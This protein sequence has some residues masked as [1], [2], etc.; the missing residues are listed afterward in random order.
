TRASLL[1]ELGLSDDSSAALRELVQRFSNVRDA[2]GLKRSF[3]A[4]MQL[5]ESSYTA[6]DDLVALYSDV[7]DDYSA[8]EQTAKDK[9]IERLARAIHDL[10]AALPSE[11][12][13]SKR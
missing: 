4:R 3:A 11:R 8:L 6:L 2:H 7:V 12:R 10:D 1:K 13:S 9:F 5:S